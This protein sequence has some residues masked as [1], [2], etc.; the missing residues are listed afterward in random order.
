ME[1]IRIKWSDGAPV[2]VSNPSQH[3]GRGDTGSTRF[4]FTA[5][6]CVDI[7]FIAEKYNEIFSKGRKQTERTRGRV[8]SNYPRVQ[9]SFASRRNSEEGLVFK[10]Q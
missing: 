1:G 4:P 2:T 5:I 10:G 3:D 7:T 8:G 9:G 6:H